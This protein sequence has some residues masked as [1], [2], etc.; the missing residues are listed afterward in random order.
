MIMIVAGSR[1]GNGDSE[2]GTATH[3]ALEYGLV[4]DGSDGQLTLRDL[5]NVQE[6]TGS[7]GRCQHNP[8]DVSRLIHLTFPREEIDIHCG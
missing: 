1:V 8:I 2:K 5:R 7:R 4:V 3:F 6:L